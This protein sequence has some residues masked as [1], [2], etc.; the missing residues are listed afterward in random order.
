MVNILFKTSNEYYG[1]R[2]QYSTTTGLYN[3]SQYIVNDYKGDWIKIQLPVKINLTKYG[4][5]QN[6]HM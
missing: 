2:Y 3:K 4:F 5:K 1:S 6:Q